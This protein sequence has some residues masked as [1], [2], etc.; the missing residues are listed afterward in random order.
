[1]QQD[2]TDREPVYWVFGP[3]RAQDGREVWQVVR[4]LPHSSGIEVVLG[5]ALTREHAQAQADELNTV[6][7]EVKHGLKAGIA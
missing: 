3:V 7:A 5:E 2:S 4:F 6:L 1:M